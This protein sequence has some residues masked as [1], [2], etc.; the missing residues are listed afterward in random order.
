MPFRQLTLEQYFA[1][2]AEEMAA[3]V[4]DGALSPVHLIEAALAAY[5]AVG[6]VLN[7][8]AWLKPDALLKTASESEKEQKA[9]RL[10]GP[11][12]GVPVAAK[13]TYL[14]PGMR[15]ACSSL[16]LTGHPA[17]SMPAAFSRS[18]MPVGMPIVGQAHDDRGLLATCRAIEQAQAGEDRL[19]PLTTAAARAI[20]DNPV[21]R[22]RLNEG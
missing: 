17:A 14:V 22:Q 20:G 11:L 16:N 2:T 5:D 21:R 18:G 4:A 8:H 3:A 7:A 19:P 12:H 9:G 13:D 10:R 15:T 6:T 1:S